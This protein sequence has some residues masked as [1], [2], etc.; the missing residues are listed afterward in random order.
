MQA[1]PLKAKPLGGG[2]GKKKGKNIL[3]KCKKKY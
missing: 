3:K 1:P 2:Q